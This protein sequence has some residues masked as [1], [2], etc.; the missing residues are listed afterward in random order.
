LTASPKKKG[1]KSHPRKNGVGRI[2]AGAESRVEPVLELA[3]E[4]GKSPRR[5]KGG[6]GQGLRT[7][8]LTDLG[9]RVHKERKG[10]SP[11]RIREYHPV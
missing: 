2:R 8:F 7:E 4:E 10:A 3:D 1:G 11:V 5:F 9:T 6:E